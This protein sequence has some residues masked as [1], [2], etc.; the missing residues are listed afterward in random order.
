MRQDNE[1][2]WVSATLH[3][4]TLNFDTP[5]GFKRAIHDGFFFIEIP[6]GFKLNAGDLFACQY[7]LPKKNTLHDD[8]RGFN[9]WTED[10]LAPR[11]GYFSRS[12]DQ[13]EQ[14]FLESR[15]WQ[16][17]FPD[18]LILQATAMQILGLAILQD[19]LTR[20][21]IPTEYWEQGT[22]L[23]LSNQGLYHLTFNH[24]RPEVRARGLNIHKDSGWITLLR[25]LESGL[26]VLRKGR[27]RSINPR[28][29]TFIVNFGCAMEILTRETSHPVSAV[30]HRVVEQPVK[31]NPL[32]DRFS[33][34]LFIDSSLD[35]RLCEGLYC[36]RPGLGLI[37]ETNFEEFLNEILKNTYNK[38]S[39]GL[40][41]RKKYICN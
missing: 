1:Y 9:Q 8:Y 23:A 38:S 31:H 25:S 3:E 32:V 22:G 27:W 7:Y 24:F 30:A 29:N 5:D 36:Y 26:E 37:L 34:A 6:S 28:P 33:Y 4:N 11:E 10:R 18:A 21:D 19:V 39:R 40:Y 2:Q 35:S 12:D 14:F 16:C 17:L 41:D 13:V 20:L 15:F